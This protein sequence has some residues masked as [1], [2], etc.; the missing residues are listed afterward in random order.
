[1]RRKF[2]ELGGAWLPVRGS[3]LHRFLGVLSV[4]AMLRASSV[5]FLPIYLWLMSQEAYASFSYIIALVGVLSLV[6]NFG[7]YVAQ[8]KLLHEFSG[9]ERADAVFTINALLAVMLGSALLPLY[10]FGWDRFIFRLVFSGNVDY[11]Q[12]RYLIPLGVVLTVYSQMLL[13]FFLTGEQIP[14]VQRY[15]ISRLLLGLLLTIGA[16]YTL[17]GDGAA[18][19]ML[20][21]SAAELIAL[22]VFF[23]SY[24]L[25]MRG[26]F[27]A[28]IARRSL[29]LGLPIM[30]SGVLGLVINFGDKFFVERYC[31]LA[32]MSVYFL[33]LT[34]SSAV[35]LVVM[36]FQNVWLPSF[37]KE[38]DLALNL[39]RTR[40]AA[41]HLVLALTVLSAVI[42]IAVA[43]C[44]SLDIFKHEYA[45][46][47]KILPIL[48]ASSVAAATTGLL[49][50]YTI[51]W[52]MTYVTVVAG[53]I[54]AA[55]SVPLNFF[56]IS[57][58]GI[59]GAAATSL[60]INVLFAVIY[61]WFVRYQVRQ[62]GPR[63]TDYGQR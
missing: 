5:V 10:A 36:A 33:G 47:L 31:T 9:Q 4:D 11:E 2:V 12:Y 48:L 21:Y 38:A 16:L 53:G 62:R 41:Y 27:S 1:M 39:R 6:C 58:F 45:P 3:M 40:R 34:L 32:D 46:V 18:V 51:Y 42:W 20:A 17:T 37:L 28:N 22:C 56:A 25:A 49:S 60:L 7:L 26:R 44:L 14:R 29:S 63:R 35:T 13:N 19:R 8:S 24:A 59:Y 50:T 23:S 52:N 43:L 57:G 55:V 54:V 30:G 61:L 15:N